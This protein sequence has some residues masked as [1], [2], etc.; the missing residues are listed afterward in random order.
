MFSKP[1]DT[2]TNWRL[3]ALIKFKIIRLKK[4]FQLLKILFFNQKCIS[5]GKTAFLL[6]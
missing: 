4:K 1:P 5:S 6:R 2:E 3:Y